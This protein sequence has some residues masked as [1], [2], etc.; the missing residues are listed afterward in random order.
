[1]Y[2]DAHYVDASVV[3]CLLRCSEFARFVVHNDRRSETSFLP[4]KPPR[5]PRRDKLND[6]AKV[7]TLSDTAKG[8]PVFFSFLTL[9]HFKQKNGTIE[10][11]IWKI[12]RKTV[13]LQK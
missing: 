10:Y 1:M 6:A 12:E 9:F 11:F 13:P 2:I 3:I 8:F 5:R 4:L 7:A